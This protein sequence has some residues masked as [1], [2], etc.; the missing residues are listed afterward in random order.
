MILMKSARQTISNIQIRGKLLYY[1]WVL[2]RFQSIDSLIRVGGTRTSRNWKAWRHKYACMCIHALQ[3]IWSNLVTD[4]HVEWRQVALA[5]MHVESTMFL[6]IYIY[7]HIYIYVW[8]CNMNTLEMLLRV[9][10]EICSF[11]V[12]K[13]EVIYEN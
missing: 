3:L 5:A 10:M 1:T 8:L 4:Q 13:F 6:Y 2:I 12:F 9:F 11:L 7:V